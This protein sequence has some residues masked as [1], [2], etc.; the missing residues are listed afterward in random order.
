ME[1][2]NIFSKSSDW[3]SPHIGMKETASLFWANIDY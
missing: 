3:Q 2:N 1:S